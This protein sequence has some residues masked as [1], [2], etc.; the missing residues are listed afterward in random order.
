MFLHQGQN[1]LKE[2]RFHPQFHTLI[3]TTAIDSFNIF[4]PNL[5]PEDEA[6]QLPDASMQDLASAEESKEVSTSSASRSTT[7]AMGSGRHRASADSSDD[8]GYEEQARAR[9]IAR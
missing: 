3:A 7:V 9:R 4:R 1:D 2:L 5:D 6:N 8:E